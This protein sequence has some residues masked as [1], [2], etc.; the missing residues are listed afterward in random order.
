MSLSLAPRLLAT[1][2]TEEPKGKTN[3]PLSLHSHPQIAFP[4]INQCSRNTEIIPVVRSPT[5]FIDVGFFLRVPPGWGDRNGFICSLASHRG[6]G[7][8]WHVC[9]AFVHT[10]VSFCANVRSYSITLEAYLS[11]LAS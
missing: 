8:V 2:D 9:T 6:K 7:N 1:D 3:S 5:W 10:S 11:Q 4:C